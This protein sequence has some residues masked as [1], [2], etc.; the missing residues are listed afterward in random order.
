MM[1]GSTDDNLRS[2]FH[3]MVSVNP[4]L[5]LNPGI[6]KPNLRPILRQRLARQTAPLQN[7]VPDLDEPVTE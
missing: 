3:S 5:A 2:R 6:A 7:H 4:W 1:S